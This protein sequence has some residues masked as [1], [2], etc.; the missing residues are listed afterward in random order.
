MQELIK[1]QLVK[2]LSHFVKKNFGPLVGFIG[3]AVI[4]S[5]ASSVFLRSDNLINVLRQVSINGL[6][7]AGITCVI[8]V[9]CIDLSVGSI[10]AVAGCLSVTLNTVLGVH[11]LLAVLIGMISGMFFGFLSGFI[12]AKTMLPPFIITLAMQQSLRGFAYIFTAGYPVTSANDSFNAI[13]NGYL[14][15]IPIP[16]IIMFMIYIIVGVILTRTKLGRHM[17]AVGGNM[18]A[19]R[20]SGISYFKVVTFAYALS[21]ALS[22]LAGVILAG[23]MYSGQPTVGEQYA[24]DAIA[25]AVIGGTAF[26]GGFG[27][28]MGTLLGVLTIGIINNGMN[29]LKVSVYFQLMVK[30]IIILGAVYF[31]SVQGKHTTKIKKKKTKDSRLPAGD[32]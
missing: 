25:A 28:M 17:Y 29:L 15:P 13:G 22:A 4:L 5:L 11:F 10:V 21:G 27:S 2:P 14:G 19:A 12:R 16:V 26:G 6:V 24:P 3:I 1:N 7:A 32:G 31:D 18:E 30:G 9:G 8:L 23:R 20:H